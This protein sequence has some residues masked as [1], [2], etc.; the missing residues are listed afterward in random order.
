MR[1]S[2]KIAPHPDIHLIRSVVALLPVIK[3]QIHVL[4]KRNPPVGTLSN[5]LTDYITQHRIQ[6]HNHR[7]I[8]HKKSPQINPAYEHQ[9]AFICVH[10]RLKIP[11]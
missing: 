11:N 2:K 5:S 3:R 8:I 4:S 1:R 6:I 7:S 9:S 10:L